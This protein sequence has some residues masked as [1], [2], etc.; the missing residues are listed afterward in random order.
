[1]KWNDYDASYLSFKDGRSNF[2]FMSSTIADA[3]DHVRMVTFR[4]VKNVSLF[5]LGTA[6]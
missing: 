1:M 6:C 5:M 3:A 4:T 2:L